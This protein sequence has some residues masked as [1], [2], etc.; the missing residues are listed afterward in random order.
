MNDEMRRLKAS[1]REYQAR[2]DHTFSEPKDDVTPRETMVSVT[3]NNPF[4][5]PVPAVLPGGKV[6]TVRYTRRMVKD[7]PSGEIR[8]YSCKSAECTKCG[9]KEYYFND[10]TVEY[11]TRPVI[12]I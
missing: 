1:L 12:K 8:L 11:S 2:C 6:T 7:Y 10:P 5:L 3:T 4:P 9:F